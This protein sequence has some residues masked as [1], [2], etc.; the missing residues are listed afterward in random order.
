M[1]THKERATAEFKRQ[2]QKIQNLLRDWRDADPED[3]DAYWYQIIDAL[4]DAT[5]ISPE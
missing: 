4:A 1:M 2:I 3:N 5:G